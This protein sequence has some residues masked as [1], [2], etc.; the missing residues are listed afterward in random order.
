[1]RIKNKLWRI[2]R[3]IHKSWSGLM[4]A[5]THY[6]N[7]YSLD[8]DITPASRTA[9]QSARDIRGITRPPALMLYGVTPRAGTNYI[10][11]LLSMHP[12]I[13]A[14]PNN[15]YEIPFL[16][17]TDKL[18]SFQNAFFNDYSRNLENMG[19]NDFLPIFGSSFISHLYSFAPENGVILTKDPD[20]RFLRYY[21]LLFPHENLLLVL[22]DGR[23]VVHSTITTWPS[24]NFK[25]ICQRWHDSARLILEFQK[26]HQNKYL[27]IKYEEMLENPPEQLAHVLRHYDL[28]TDSYPFDAINSMPIIGSSTASK[29]DGKVNWKPVESDGNFKP[30]NKWLTWTKQQKNIFK[31]IAG[32]TLIECG[33][34]DDLNW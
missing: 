29:V 12:D 10:G 8:F 28:D 6:H 5:S 25:S 14:Y 23:D 24:M 20:V 34:S 16:C 17:M 26:R 4:H 31:K 33:Y 3:N 2:K 11:K 22:R 27:L 30:T 19:E 1:M 13:T 21:P 9:I 15:I 7:A 18:Q 32:N